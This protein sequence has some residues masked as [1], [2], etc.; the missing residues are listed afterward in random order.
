MNI[1]FCFKLLS[2]GITYYAAVDDYYTIF[3]TFISKS[4]FLTDQIKAKVA[5]RAKVLNSDRL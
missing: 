5:K 2:I 4:K 3:L 1:Y